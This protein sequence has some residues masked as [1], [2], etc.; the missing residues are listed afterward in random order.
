MKFKL[1]TLGWILLI[2]LMF[3]ICGT[4]SAQ[5]TH[6]NQPKLQSITVTP[7]AFGPLGLPNS[8]EWDL[9]PVI[10]RGIVTQFNYPKNVYKIGYERQN[11][12]GSTPVVGIYNKK[13]KINLDFRNYSKGGVMLSV[14][15]SITIFKRN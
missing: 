3:G 4:C 8:G 12:F 15:K 9:P 14:S 1:D 6:P 7:Y 13:H 10:N 2:L 11:I 5:K